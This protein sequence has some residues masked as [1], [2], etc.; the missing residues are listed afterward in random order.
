MRTVLLNDAGIQKIKS[1]NL[2]IYSREIKEIKGSVKAGDLVRLST[3]S[4][5]FLGV[6]YI[7]PLSK[8]TV[9][10]LSF[11]DVDIDEKFLKERVEK[12]YRLREDLFSKTNAIRIIHAEADFLPGL[13][14]DY[15]DG[16]LS[17]Q[18]NTAGMER[19]REYIIK[20]LLDVINPKGMIDKSDRVSRQIEG[21][22]PQENNVYGDIPEDIIIIENDIRFSINLMNSQKTGF[23]L[24]QRANR[25]KVS[26]YVKEGSVVLDLFSNTG[27]F[28]IYAASRGADFVKFVDI[29]SSAISLIEKNIKLNRYKNFSIV[30]SDVFDFLKDELKS[31]IKYDV[32]VL[33]PPPFAKSKNEREGALRGFKYLILNSLK[34]LEKDGYLAVFSCSHHIS[35]Q[36]LIDITFEA[37]R[38]TGFTVRYLDFLKQDIDHPYILNIPNSFYLKG[39]LVQKV[40]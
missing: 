30:K 11:E 18:I 6:G 38:D 27:G 25:E 4:G 36:D 29:S 2:W 3:P 35:H 28:G 21:L 12:A 39:F 8:I 40:K 16:Y 1:K 26:S 32:I 31:G 7:N 33:D 15:Y 34:L 22:C 14:V 24:D 37:L 23:Y 9:R 20:A 5:K 13:I 10:V 17:I 19:L